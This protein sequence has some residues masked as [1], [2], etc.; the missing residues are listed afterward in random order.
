MKDIKT[1]NVELP[2]QDKKICELLMMEIDKN[3]PG[4]ESKV[5]HAHP[6]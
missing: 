6:V 3:L 5:W 2:E 4:A 1:Y